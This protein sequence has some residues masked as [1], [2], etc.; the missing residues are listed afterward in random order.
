MGTMIDTLVP[1]IEREPLPDLFNLSN[2]ELI[3]QIHSK[4]LEAG[5][6]I[7]ETNSFSANAVTLKEYG[8]EKRLGEINY[9]AATIAKAEAQRYT[10]L[11]PSKP[12]FV[13]GVLGPG[14]KS[15]SISTDLDNPIKRAISFREVVNSYLLQAEAL[16][17]G[18]VDAFMVETIYDTLNAKAALYALDIL[19]EESGRELPIMVSATI[20]GESGRLLSGQSI[21]AFLI[22]ISHHSLF[23]VG[24]NCSFGPES[25][26]PW[27]RALSKSAKKIL[28]EDL[29]ISVHPNAGLPDIMG[30]YSQ[31]PEVMGNYILEYLDEGVVD[32]VGGCCGTTP[33]HIAEMAK[34]VG[35][36]KMSRNRGD[37]GEQFK[38]K[39]EGR[40]L[41]LSGLDSLEATKEVGMIS[42]GE[43]TNVAG[44][45]KFLNIIREGN[46]REGVEIARKMVDGG[47]MVIDINSDD[48]MLDSV[49][50]MENF[51][52]VLSSDP[53]VAR[54][55]IMIDSSN[56][57]VQRA[58]LE[59]LQGKGVVN[60]IS[61]KEGEELFM[62]R[63]KEIRRYGAAVVVMAFD[64][65]GE[66]DTF[67]R[68]VEVCS[69]AFT[70]LTEKA[71]FKN[72]DIIFDTNIFPVATGMEEH[73]ENALN[74]FRAAEWIVK[75]LPGCGILG[76][77]SNLSFAFRGNNYI[78]E[79]MHSVFLYHAIKS[80]MNLAIVNPQTLL[81]YQSIE[82]DL[83]LAI[84][85]VLFNRG[86]NAT[87]HLVELASKKSRDGGVTLVVEN[88]AKDEKERS[89]INVGERIANSIVR[90]DS[91]Y[92]SKDIEEALSS[93][94]S[95]NFIIDNFLMD[96]MREVGQ[97]F[98]SGK[99]FLPQ[100][101]KSAWV[102]KEAVGLVTPYIEG[103]QQGEHS[104]GKI[105]KRKTPLVLLATVR[106]DV[107]DIGKN[108]VSTLLTC[109]GFKVVDLGIMVES[110][111]IVES[112]IALKPDVI[113]LSGLITPSLAE[114][115][116]VVTL[117]NRRALSMPVLIGGATTSKTY[118]AV[119]I[120]PH[121]SGSIIYVPDASMAVTTVA[122]L[123]N[124]NSSESYKQS[125]A[126]EYQR[127]ANN[128]HGRRANKV[129]LSLQE[130]R[131]NRAL[132]GWE[133]VSIPEV[134]PITKLTLDVEEVVP[135]IEWRQYVKLWGVDPDMESITLLN[136]Q[137]F[138]IE[139]LYAIYSAHSNSDDCIVIE[140]SNGE[141]FKMP[142]LRQQWIKR[143]GKH[144]LAL[145]D[146]VQEEGKSGRV[147]LFSLKV[148][149]KIDVAVAEPLLIESL[150]HRLADAAST[151]LHKKVWP[152]GIKPAPGFPSMPD[153]RAKKMIFRLLES[154]ERLGIILTQGM[155][156][157]PTSSICGFYFFHPKSNYFGVG[158]IDNE[159]LLSY[160]QLMGSSVT[161][162][163]KWLTQHI[164]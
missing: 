131:N 140:N 88:R 2:R 1:T 71:G 57:E 90:G 28:G 11:N 29:L 110:E 56:W 63:A 52:K 160:S 89:A 82:S 118:C 35:G 83:I 102:M 126:E 137:N 106:G 109:N 132:L 138:T 112:A 104:S 145:S 129:L 70:L 25:L 10:Q 111:K 55:P 116:E 61:L 50:E 114:M 42:I 130:A 36:R 32:I 163:K 155:G 31:T 72:E 148:E 156:M 144:N 98:N 60:S 84:E 136:S 73:R 47:A 141:L 152:T 139:A 24:L 135:E 4:Y 5:A 124:P 94:Y 161:E 37:S 38:E 46:Y 96:G 40:T 6:D 14:S 80:G 85:D 74:F 113:G 8:V 159:Q 75:N 9:A 95:G 68:R 23:S 18:G 153:H 62:V 115:I 142:T 17:R 105:D 12:R 164:I 77:V 76:G 13:A 143:E 81:P 100:V 69:R 34:I 127:V 149:S 16:Q 51:I 30:N 33:A 151:L 93:H 53:E 21:E 26:K 97:L 134:T 117:L 78:R 157:I 39:S 54:V 3:S 150:S 20:S 158:V 58:A 7:I 162:S 128:Y 49:V 146:F 41:Y 133:G 91:S 125:V 103:E 154:Q 86:D 44:S 22:S 123:T 99:M 19:R 59:L 66:A 107:H 108:I 43:R 92:L 48:P 87:Q 27:V 120:A 147:G 79:A 121:Y 101:I 122:Q 15:A 67:D 119:K 64:E 45:K 65:R